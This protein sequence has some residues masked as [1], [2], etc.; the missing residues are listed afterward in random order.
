[1]F[2]RLLGPGTVIAPGSTTEAL[3]KAL[4]AH[5]ATQDRVAALD[6]ADGDATAAVTRATALY[7]EDGADKAA[8]LASILTL[9]GGVLGTSREIPWSVVLAAQAAQADR[10]SAPGQALAGHR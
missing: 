5:V 7:A 1:R 10:L 8:L 2:T 6:L 9:P 3:H 4:L